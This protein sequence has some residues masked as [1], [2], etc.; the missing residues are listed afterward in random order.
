MAASGVIGAAQDPVGGLLVAAALTPKQCSAVG[1]RRSRTSAAYAFAD[2]G[3]ALAE[4][5]VALDELRFEVGK[6][7]DHVLEH[8]DL[9]VAGRRGADADGR[10]ADDL[11]DMAG[12]R[13]ERALDDHGEGAGRLHRLGVLDDVGG[14][15]F[16]RGRA[17]ESRRRC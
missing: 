7:P 1:K 10:H 11:G 12:D 14:F 17:S 2:L 13:L 6:Q 4:F 16:L 8:Q 3:D 15:L 9:A 5:G